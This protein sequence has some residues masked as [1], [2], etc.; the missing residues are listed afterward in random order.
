MGN[1]PSRGWL[2][3]AASPLPGK[4]RPATG[5]YLMIPRRRRISVACSAR[6]SGEFCLDMPVGFGGAGLGWQISQG[7]A[8][9]VVARLSADLCSA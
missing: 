1:A 3:L 6:F 9:S 2:P 5:L 7:V 4:V 8:A